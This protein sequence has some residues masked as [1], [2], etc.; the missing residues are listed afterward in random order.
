[1]YQ[2]I[3]F[4]EHWNWDTWTGE[5]PEEEYAEGENYDE[6]HCDDENFIVSWFYTSRNYYIN[7]AQREMS[8]HNVLLLVQM[9]ADYDPSLHTAS[10][11]KKKKERMKLNKED[12]PQMGKRRK[13]SHF[14]EVITKEKPVFDPR[15]CPQTS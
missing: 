13:K 12:L 4:P 9:D 5:E 3:L 10:K 11:K 1:M 7:L 6:P 15:K 8:Q 14:A 2:N